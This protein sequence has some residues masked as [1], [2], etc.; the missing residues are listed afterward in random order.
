MSTCRLPS[1]GLP[2][3]DVQPIRDR[4]GMGSRALLAYRPSQ[5]AALAAPSVPA[6][7]GP[8]H[9]PRAWRQRLRREVVVGQWGL[10][11]RFAKTAKLSFSTNNARSEELATKAT[12]KHPRKRGQRCI[13]PAANFD[14]PN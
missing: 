14:E 12:F 4:R 7:A 2:C 9:P 5:P 6:C 13:I 8:L 11:P 10:T 1:F 3:A